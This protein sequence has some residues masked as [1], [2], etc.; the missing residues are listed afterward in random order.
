M[1]G[2]VNGAI[3]AAMNPLLAHPAVVEGFKLRVLIVN[4][5]SGGLPDQR[6]RADVGP[7]VHDVR[8]QE[9]VSGSTPVVV[10]KETCGKES[11][12]PKWKKASPHCCFAA[13]RALAPEPAE[14]KNSNG[15]RE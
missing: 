6:R 5:R 10:Q 7:L 11:H 1:R 14:E 12:H 2:E 8:W 15:E 9:R 4:G 13:G 3:G